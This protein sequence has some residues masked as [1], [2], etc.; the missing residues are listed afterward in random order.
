MSCDIHTVIIAIVSICK[1]VINA[2]A[3]PQAEALFH[4]RRGMRLRPRP[5][6][7]IIQVNCAVH[8]SDR[9]VALAV[10]NYATIL[11]MN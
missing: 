9:L 5:P 11:G 4:Y 2:P 10:A 8:T 6:F 3:E 7:A 1:L